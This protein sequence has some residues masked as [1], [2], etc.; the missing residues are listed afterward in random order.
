MSGR[1]R[2]SRVR[3]VLGVAIGPLAIIGGASAAF[4]QEIVHTFNNPSFGGNPF[5]SEHLL[6]IAGIDRPE[7][8]EEPTEPAPTAEELL[9]AQLRAS[10]TSSL[11]SNILQTIQTARPGDT[12]TFVVGAQ[13]ISYVRTATET[14]VTFTNTTT[15]ETSELVIPVRGAPTSTAS[16]ASS[17]SAEQALGANGATP[18]GGNGSA[19]AGNIPLTPGSLLGQPPL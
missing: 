3:L 4:A 1:A 12:G 8:P 18:V 11:S 16:A 19:S 9:V 7:A 13:R 17:M 2:R 10:L 6:A 15:G 5:Y 14:R